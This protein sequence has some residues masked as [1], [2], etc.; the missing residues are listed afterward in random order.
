MVRYGEAFFT[1][2]GF[3]PLPSTFWERSLF[4]KPRDREVVCHAS[5]WDIDTV[6]D[7]RIKMCIDITDEDFRDIHHE[8]GHNFYQRAYNRQPM[9]F[10]DSA[11]DGFHEA[12]G[13]AIALS[14]T[15]EYLA[16]LGLIQ[17]G[18]RPLEGHGPAD[19]EGAG[20][21]RLPALRPGH[22]SMALEGV[23][24]RDQAG[25]LHQ[26]LERAAPEVPGHRPGRRAHGARTFDAFAKYHVAANVPYTRYFL[27]DIL[28]FQFH[29][30]MA[31][32]GRMH[33]AA[34]HRCSIYGSKAAGERLNAMLAMGQSQPWPEALKALTGEIADG[35]HRH[36]GLLRAAEEVARPAEPGQAGRL[37][38][39]GVRHENS[40]HLR[41]ELPPMLALAGPVVLAELGWMA[42]GTVDTIML[43][44]VGR[45]ALGGAST[46]EADPSLGGAVRLGMLLGMD[47]LVAQAFGAKEL[48]DCDHTLRQGVWLA[49]L[50]TP[51]ADAAGRRS[52]RRCCARSAWPKMCSA[53]R[54]PTC[55][56][57]TGAR[58]RCSS[59]P[60][61]AA[62]CRAWP[63]CGRS[64]S[65]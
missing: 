62:T 47:T 59:M 22:R 54:S 46:A 10:R 45:E 13:D 44:R 28:Q 21:D 40:Q 37:V 60:R 24:G 5:A 49:V 3:A 17:P 2:L 41:R 65:R 56:R 61:S 58:C 33:R 11:N 52:R 55:G 8:L 12:I 34:L 63:W 26:E 30:A 51:R 57:S 48:D 25:R 39:V 20:E 15:P 32:A 7:L 19:A 38:A 9:L 18:A 6:D 27:A 43:G 31:R 64:C 1:S 29:R 50:M 35:R 14:V 53:R 23:R 16:K 4:T 42:M 36:P